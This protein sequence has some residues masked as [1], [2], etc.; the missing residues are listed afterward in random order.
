MWNDVLQAFLIQTCSEG[1]KCLNTP[2]LPMRGIWAR[3]SRAPHWGLSSSH[4]PGEWPNSC[5]VIQ[6]LGNLCYYWGL[7]FFKRWCIFNSCFS[8]KDKLSPHK[9]LSRRMLLVFHTTCRKPRGFEML[10]PGRSSNAQKQ[11]F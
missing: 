11:S 3:G 9:K 5:A 4:L 10:G 6:H 2:Y 8:N 1:S 7:I